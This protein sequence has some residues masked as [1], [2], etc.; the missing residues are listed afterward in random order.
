M[1]NSNRLTTAHPCITQGHINPNVPDGAGP[2]VF[3]I[4]DDKQRLQ[5]IGT[6]LELRSALRICIG[7][8]PEKAH[9]YR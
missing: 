5:Y 1:S 9:F 2:C 8:R 7:R 3:A 4:Y 6:A